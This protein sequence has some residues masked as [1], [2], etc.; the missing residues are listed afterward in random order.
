MTLPL[1]ARG[2]PTTCCPNCASNVLQVRA[3]FDEGTYE[4]SMYMLNAECAKCG[5]LVTA[6]TPEDLVGGEKER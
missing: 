6:P 3:I 1:D 2:I 4:I 5:T